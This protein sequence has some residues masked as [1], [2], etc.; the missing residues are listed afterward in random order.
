MVYKTKEEI[1]IISLAV[2]P[3]HFEKST[4]RS[5]WELLAWF[6]MFFWSGLGCLGVCWGAS[7]LLVIAAN[8]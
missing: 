1:E 4:Q 6:S 2:Y 3:R 8:S 5:V 7:W